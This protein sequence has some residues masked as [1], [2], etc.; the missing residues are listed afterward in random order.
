MSLSLA[1]LGDYGSDEEE[2]LAPAL[3]VP[4]AVSAY[5]DEDEDED[6]DEDDGAPAAHASAADVEMPQAA[7]PDRGGPTGRSLLPSAD[8]LLSGWSP[9]ACAAPVP[10]RTSQ[11]TNTP[12][13]RVGGHLVPPQVSRGKANLSTEDQ[14]DR[15]ARPAAP[16]P[17]PAGKSPAAAPVGWRAKEKRK[18]ELGQQAGGK[19]DWVQDEKR[20]LRHASANYD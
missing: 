8:D 13:Q 16:A 10:S 19:S 5:A 11:P 1:L 9:A 18:R 12:Q 6:K 3:A 15:T 7:A 4:G 17:T 14:S 20:M 2:E